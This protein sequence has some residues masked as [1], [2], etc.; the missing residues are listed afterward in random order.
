MTRLETKRK[1]QFSTIR[2]PDLLAADLSPFWPA[3]LRSICTSWDTHTHTHIHTHLPFSPLSNQSSNHHL[4][5]T[6]SSPSHSR[7]EIKEKYGDKLQPD[8]QGSL[9][10]VFS[11]VMRAVVGRKVTVPGSYKG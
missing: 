8:L 4:S 5:T 10:E 3:H 2:M 11:K 7:E 1:P 6:T 9:H